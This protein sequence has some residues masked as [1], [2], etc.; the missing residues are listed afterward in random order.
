MDAQAKLNYA[1]GVV[2]HEKIQSGPVP[3]VSDRSKNLQ[4]LLNELG[5]RLE[6]SPSSVPALKTLKTGPELRF[7]GDRYYHGLN[8]RRNV[9]KALAYY[10]AA[11]KKGDMPSL[12]RLVGLHL[13][14]VLSLT[15]GLKYGEKAAVA[16]YVTPAV[17]MMGKRLDGAP[18]GAERM[19]VAAP[20]LARAYKQRALD[21]EREN[22]RK[23]EFRRECSR[24]GCEL[25]GVRLLLCSACKGKPYCSEECQQKDWRVRHK[26]ECPGTP[27]VVA[28]AAG[29]PKTAKPSR[30]KEARTVRIGANGQLEGFTLSTGTLG[31][32]QMKEMSSHMT[33]LALGLDKEEYAKKGHQA[34]NI[35]VGS[36]VELAHHVPCRYDVKMTVIEQKDDSDTWLCSSEDLLVAIYMKATDLLLVP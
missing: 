32:A 34:P 31:S 24:E 25:T 8:A 14:D 7:C 29:G 36:K 18:G 13:D 30:S 4:A 27:G 9:Q 12:S 16:G 21:L 10:T 1:N 6:N 17:V 35:K 5:K 26:S 33:K 2:N 28:V 19:A 15:V 3:H 20:A 23:E 22:E 11:A